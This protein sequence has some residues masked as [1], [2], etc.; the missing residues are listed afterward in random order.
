MLALPLRRVRETTNATAAPDARAVARARRRQRRRRLSVSSQQLISERLSGDL[1]SR[2][3]FAADVTVGNPPQRFSLI[4]DTGSSITALPCAE[5]ERCGAHAN[6]PFVPASSRTFE[7]VGCDQQEYGCTSCRGNAC[8]YHVSYQ[9]GSSYSGYLA[10]D[11]VRLGAGGACAALRFAFG[12]ATVESG[13]F[14]S[15]Q[16]DG[17]MGLASSRHAKGGLTALEQALVQQAAAVA[18][19][20]AQAGSTLS[21]GASSAGSA[22][23]SVDGTTTTTTTGGGGGGGGLRGMRVAEGGGW[24][25]GRSRGGEDERGGGGEDPTLTAARSP[26]VREA[27]AAR[28]CTRVHP[29]HAGA[30]RARVCTCRA[31]AHVPR[32]RAPRTPH[33]CAVPAPPTCMR[34]CCARVDRVQVL[35]A[36]VIS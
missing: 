5:C 16:A 9:E 31:R 26:T 25:F 13:H 32:T 36:L 15:Q 19:D 35:E 20:A 34:T 30:A 14:R 27:H 21:D 33:A 10:T 17:I 3:Y 2:G 22:A 8:A 29:T 23:A 28:A 18:G 1:M 6:P 11:V 4:V 7:P 24:P 12:C